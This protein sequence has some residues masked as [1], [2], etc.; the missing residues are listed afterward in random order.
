MLNA[1]FR[2]EGQWA[3]DSLLSS[4][5]FGVGGVNLGRGYDSSEIIGDDGVAGSLEFQLND[6]FRIRHI[7]E[8][9]F[10]AFYDAG[11]VWNESPSDSS[12]KRDTITSTG[13]GFRFGVLDNS[14]RVDAFAALPLN[15]EVET[16][17]DEDMRFFFSV[18]KSF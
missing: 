7:D 5:E 13:A 15:R 6:P 16:E 17:G 9:Q 4:E 14:L 18:T 2:F 11:R 8:P 10:Y 12:L 3:T 1:L